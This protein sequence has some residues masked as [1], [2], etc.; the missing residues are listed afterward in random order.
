MKYYA[1]GRPVRESTRV[2]KESEARRI[3]KEREGRLATGQPV[4]PRADRVRYEEVTND[5][6]QHYQATGS[7]DM[8]ELEGRLAHLDHVFAGRRVSAI[9]Q[10]DVTTYV[11]HRQTKGAANGTINRELGV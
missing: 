3:L 7:R 10:P 2:E 1:N 8:V 9:G 11:L 5:L 4:L 6:R